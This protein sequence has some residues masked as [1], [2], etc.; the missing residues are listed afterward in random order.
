VTDHRAFDYPTIAREAALI[1]D[2]RNVLSGVPERG[3]RVVAL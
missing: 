1:V 2:V 3:G